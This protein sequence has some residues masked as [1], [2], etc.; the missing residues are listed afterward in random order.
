MQQIIISGL[1]ENLARKCPI[2]DANG[3]EIKQTNKMKATYE[4]QESKERLSLH[5]FSSLY[6]EKPE[7][8]VYQEIYALENPE[9]GKMKYYL[10]GATKIDNLNWIYNLSSPILIQT[11][12]PITEENN[13]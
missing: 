12:K 3:N 7:F 8:L 9:T 13:S 5:P 2:F 6:K 1:C 10:K 11:S 4:S